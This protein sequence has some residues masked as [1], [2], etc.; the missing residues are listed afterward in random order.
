M[1]ARHSGQIR[2]HRGS[3]FG[4]L[5]DGYEGVQGVAATRTWTSSAGALGLLAVDSVTKNLDRGFAAVARVLCVR[6]V[7]LL[8][9]NLRL[10]SHVSHPEASKQ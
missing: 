1:R 8:E 10:G 4:C 7:M 5:V 3:G 6:T 9:I 2:D